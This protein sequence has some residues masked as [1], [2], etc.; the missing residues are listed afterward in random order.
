MLFLFVALFLAV[1]GSNTDETGET[2]K[3]SEIFPDASLVAVVAHALN[4][5]VNA[6][7]EIQKLI[8]LHTL[9]VN[10]VSRDSNRRQIQE[11]T[12]ING[13]QDLTGIGYL[14]G[15]TMANLANNQISDFSPLKALNLGT[16]STFHNQTITLPDGVVNGETEFI[17]KNING[18]A[19]P[20]IL[21]IG[22][23]SF[24]NGLLT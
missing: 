16:N 21:G 14:E 9:D 20:L 1:C 3:I 11:F 6:E 7:V 23:L 24:E 5:N 22:D 10:A 17:L 12:G 2:I 15:L 18:E 8:N 19:I 4:V 13:I